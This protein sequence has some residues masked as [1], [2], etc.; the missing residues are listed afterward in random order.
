MIGWLKSK[1][2]V[3]PAP[4]PKPEMVK[5]YVY[6]GCGVMEEVLIPKVDF[7]KQAKAHDEMIAR[8]N[9]VPNRNR[10][11]PA[12]S[13]APSTSSQASST[14]TRSDDSSLYYLAAYSAYDSTPSHSP[15][16]YDGGSCDSSSPSSCD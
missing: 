3:N 11:K 2:Q 8:M 1:F 16:G 6:V 15:S 7:D 9:S 5:D 12:H 4:P 10:P 14:P 13:Q